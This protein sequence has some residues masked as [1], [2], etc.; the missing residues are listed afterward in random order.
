[1]WFIFCFL[2]V[3]NQIQGLKFFPT[4]KKSWFSIPGFLDN[5]SFIFCYLL[6]IGNVSQLDERRVFILTLYDTQHNCAVGT[7]GNCATIG[8]RVLFQLIGEPFD[9]LGS[10]LRAKITVERRGRSTLLHVTYKKNSR[11]SSS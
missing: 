5:C 6:K 3:T 8:I 1:M 4:Q 10:H 2:W 7:I 9:R 11:C